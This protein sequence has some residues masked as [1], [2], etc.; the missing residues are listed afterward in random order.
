MKTIRP[1][2]HLALSKKTPATFNFFLVFFSS[3]GIGGRC[4]VDA[5]R[6]VPLEEE[7]DDDILDACLDGQQRVQHGCVNVLAK[8]PSKQQQQQQQPKKRKEKKED[9]Q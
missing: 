7:D 2:C 1:S 5:D 9:K 3:H 6:A 4:R 8:V